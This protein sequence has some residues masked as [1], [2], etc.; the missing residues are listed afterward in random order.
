MMC[1]LCVDSSRGHVCAHFRVTAL[2]ASRDKVLL[3]IWAT[4]S[5]TDGLRRPH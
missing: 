3:A 2:G 1:E 5:L 4:S